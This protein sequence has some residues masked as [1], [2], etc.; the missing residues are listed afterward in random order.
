[1]AIDITHLQDQLHQKL[2]KTDV[3]ALPPAKRLALKTA[4]V[5]F[6]VIHEIAVGQLTLRAMSLI[7]TTLISMVPLLAVSFSVLKA[8]GVHDKVEPFLLEFLAPLGDKGD[9]IGTNI[10]EFINNINVGVL[11]TVGIGV[12]F[13]TVISLV[14]KI[15]LTFNHIWHVRS[16]RTLLRR[17]TDYLSV[18]MIGPVMV[19][20]ALALTAT[21]VSSKFVQYIIAIE[22]FG[23][24]FYY[25]GLMIPY[26]LI[27][28]AFGFMYMFIPNTNVR[29]VPALIGATVAGILWKL[30]G[31]AFAS[32]TAGSSNYDAIYS[33]FAILIMFM[34]WLYLSWLIFLLG[35][36]IAFFCQHQEYVRPA[37]GDENIS[38]RQ[39]E[40]L[41]L[42]A[43]YWIATHYIQGK[44]A[45]SLDTLSS[46][47]KTPSIPLADLLD[48]LVAE[49]LLISITN[50][51]QTTYVPAK[52]LDTFTVYDVVSTI[53]NTHNKSYINTVFTPE[54]EQVLQILDGAC[55]S[56]LE[57]KSVR[58]W[59]VNSI[60][61]GD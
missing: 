41:G 24:L 31:V 52:D 58:E 2:W 32:F 15:E 6:A 8:F 60:P 4:R 26:V 30:A 57:D 11:G 33:S 9:E 42:E 47:L 7:Y 59:V 51:N 56:A 39:K 37:Q 25:S 28:V 5:I 54:V 12:L 55:A 16:S 20:S 44:P 43:I 10:I 53:R 23:S 13:Y 46:Q 19:V 1:M 49:E 35:S 45:W 36:Q 14:Q 40:K 38:C 34:I 61:E 17:I 22:P 21:M 29:V 18:L 3:D 50:D 27:I 48:C